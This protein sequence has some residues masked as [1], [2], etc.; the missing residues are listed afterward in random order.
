MHI[1]D[2]RDT[3]AFPASHAL[4]YRA[5]PHV[6]AH[7]AMASAASAA[8]FDR[9]TPQDSLQAE[10]RLRLVPATLAVKLRGSKLADR[11]A[12]PG[13][14]RCPR[15]RLLRNASIFSQGEPVLC[16]SASG[17][18]WVRL[19]SL[20]RVP[21]DLFSRPARFVSHSSQTPSAQTD[22]LSTAVPSS[23]V[24]DWRY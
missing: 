3:T 21:S 19:N 17:W 7:D 22:S 20:I 12:R 14:S 13:S 2:C 6:H 4:K 8:W 1:E 5:L 9:K 16:S 10:L 24:A 11:L 18:T 23:A 15:A